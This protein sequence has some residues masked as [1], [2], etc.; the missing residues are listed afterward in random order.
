M[1]LP[2]LNPQ[3]RPAVDSRSTIVFVHGAVVNGSEMAL[4]RRRLRQLGYGVRLF[5]YQS[6]LKG[7]D[8]NVD[9]LAAFIGSTEGDTIHVV[10]HSMGG[11]LIRHVFERRPD[12][13]PGRLI[14]IGS[15]LLDCWVGR[16]FLRIHPR[17]GRYLIGRTVFDHIAHPRDPIW[18][19]TRDFGVIAGTYP[20]G[21]GAVFKSLPK[22]SDGVVLLDETRLGGINDHV[23]YRL[24][25]FGMLF[26][27]RCCAQLARFLAL[28]SFAHATP[29]ASGSESERMSTVTA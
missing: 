6:M 10:G 3:W 24:N 1:A 4:L 22:P 16:R 23:T 29:A 2:W 26:S 7:L 11:V 5:Q 14:A 19:G 18:R 13:R 28:G 20:F 9:R 17:V 12:P 15:P 25:H 8:K 21:I 27:K